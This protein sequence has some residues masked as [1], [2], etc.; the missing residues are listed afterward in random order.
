MK[1]AVPAW[2]FADLRALGRVSLGVSRPKPTLYGHNQG[3]GLFRNIVV[4]CLVLNPQQNL[5]GATCQSHPN[6]IQLS[7]T[8]G[9][10]STE[11]S[12]WIGSELEDGPTAVSSA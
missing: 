11:A 10:V 2:Q 9:G 1:L 4:I 5:N 3:A 12:E 7:R 8:C 6:G